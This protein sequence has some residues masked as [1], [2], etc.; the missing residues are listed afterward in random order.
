[1]KEAV[2]AVVALHGMRGQAKGL[3]TA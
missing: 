1:M 3:L 2:P